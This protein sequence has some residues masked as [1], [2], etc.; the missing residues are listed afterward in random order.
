MFNKYKIKF[1]VHT[2]DSTFNGN[3]YS[4]ET[5]QSYKT[6]IIIK[7][8]K[9]NDNY[10]ATYTAPT[11]H[12][13]NSY[14]LPRHAIM[15]H[16]MKR[17]SQLG[18]LPPKLQKHKHA[19]KR[20]DTETMERAKRTMQHASHWEVVPGRNFGDGQITINQNVNY[21]TKTT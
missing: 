10:T 14:I 19:T 7:Q 21:K 13:T 4:K 1:N 8:Q 3:V 18:Q 20:H 6:L 16:S 15:H 11:G 2:L 12:I 17:K 9:T 5:L